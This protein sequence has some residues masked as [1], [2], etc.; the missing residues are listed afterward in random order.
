MA[1]LGRV[2][3]TR[4]GSRKDSTYRFSYSKA[5]KTPA[6][7]DNGGVEIPIS[8]PPIALLLYFTI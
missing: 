6:V 2:A 1:T 7:K 5:G 4:K 3:T 8:T